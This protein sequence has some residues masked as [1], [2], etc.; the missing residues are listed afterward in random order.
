MR[1][2]CEN[3]IN[4]FW[5]WFDNL[6]PKVK[7]TYMYAYNDIAEDYFQEFYGEQSVNGYMSACEAEVEGSLPSVHPN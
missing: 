4:R 6:S 5:D 1:L 2:K 3:E 7:Q